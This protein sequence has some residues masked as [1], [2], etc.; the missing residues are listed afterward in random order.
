MNLIRIVNYLFRECK[1]L[2]SS[3]KASTAYCPPTH[4]KDDLRR[5]EVALEQARTTEPLPQGMWPPNTSA[6]LWTWRP[7]FQHFTRDG[8]FS[9]QNSV[10]IEITTNNEIPGFTLANNTIYTFIEFLHHL[11]SLLLLATFSLFAPSHCHPHF[12][13]K[14]PPAINHT[15]VLLLSCHLAYL[16]SYFLS[17]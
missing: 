6:R 16:V 10:L 2:W 1:T 12:S 7:Q 14:P 8:R 3:W 9:L 13:S 5:P 4:L 15:D 17:N 11:I